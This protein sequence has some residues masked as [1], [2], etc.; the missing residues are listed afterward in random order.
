V[1]IKFNWG[2]GIVLAIVVMVTGLGV[3]IGISMYQ[4]F[5]LVDKDYYQ[6]GIHY[7][8]HIEKI[9]NT[10]LLSEK[11]TYIKEDG[12]LI[13]KFPALLKNKVLKGQVH[14]YCPVNSDNDYKTSIQLNDSLLQVVDLKSLSPGRYIIKLDWYSDTVGYYQEFDL[15]IE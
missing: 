12:K 13:L 14:F 6:K 11:I 2:T 15:K 7:Q 9:K 8:E 10:D 3:L 5:D 1:K 4:D